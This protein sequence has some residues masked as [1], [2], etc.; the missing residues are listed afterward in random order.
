M[1]KRISMIERRRYKEERKLVAQ[2]QI[3]INFEAIFNKVII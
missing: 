1:N 3:I 2:G